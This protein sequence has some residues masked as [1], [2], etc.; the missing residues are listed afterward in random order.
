MIINS[1][2]IILLVSLLL[3]ITGCSTK[4]ITD[5]DDAY[6]ADAK[7]LNGELFG[8]SICMGKDYADRLYKVDNSPENIKSGTY[9]ILNPPKYVQQYRTMI[10]I[11]GKKDIFRDN[12]FSKYAL[13]FYTRDSLISSIGV[14]IK[15]IPGEKQRDRIIKY[16]T[17]LLGPP[18]K[19]IYADN[20]PSFVGSDGPFTG[21]F[22][23]VWIKP[24]ANKCRNYNFLQIR[25]SGGDKVAYY[26]IV[27]EAKIASNP[28]GAGILDHKIN[29]SSMIATR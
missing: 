9:G 17:N 12:V 8:L 24:M 10:E 14:W 29:L 20:K 15:S 4:S 22:D 11:V 2:K 5:N 26:H 25:I 7:I 16:Y 19:N 23:Y 3:I 13:C 28:L 21:W 18:D 6:F 1:I 27:I